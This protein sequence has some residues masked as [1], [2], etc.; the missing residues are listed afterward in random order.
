MEEL[1]KLGSAVSDGFVFM[2]TR[3]KFDN[4]RPSQIETIAFNEF[5]P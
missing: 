3:V 1:D 4:G 5:V 2:G